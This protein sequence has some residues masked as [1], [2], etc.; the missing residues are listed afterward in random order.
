MSAFPDSHCSCFGFGPYQRDIENSGLKQHADFEIV[1]RM[2]HNSTNLDGRGI[3]SAKTLDVESSRT[4]CSDL[5]TSTQQVK[6]SARQTK[7][8]A[9]TQGHWSKDRELEAKITV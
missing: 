1:R 8:L 7:E 4:P 5:P 3:R 9:S 2:R 6:S